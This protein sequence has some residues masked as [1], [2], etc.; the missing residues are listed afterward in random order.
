MEEV[1]RVKRLESGALGLEVN[2]P[3]SPPLVVLVGRRAFVACGFLNVE[4]AERM[5]APCARVTGVRS[6]EDVL[7]KEI[8]EATTKAREL[9][10]LPGLKVRDVL[11]KL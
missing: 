8:A 5:G 6:V 11:D 1:L 7:E 3:G 10:I 9:G 2:L 4:V